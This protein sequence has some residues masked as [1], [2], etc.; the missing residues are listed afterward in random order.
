MQLT[1]PFSYIAKIFILSLMLSSNVLAFFSDKGPTYVDWKG[2]AIKG[3]DTVAYFTENKSVK[4]KKEFEYEW[5]HGKWLFTSQ[6]NL[7]TF[8]ANPKKYAPQY[9]GYC[10]YAAAAVNDLV[11]I[12]PKQFNIV[13]GKLY[14]NFNKKF[15][16]KWN[17][18]SDQYI[19]D[20]DKN[21]PELLAK[22]LKTVK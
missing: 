13:D 2:F 9:G 10:A 19:V 3:Y 7:D 22:A 20:G 18:N 16:D 5:N 6:Q 12:D 14:L 4:G 21:W 15:N 1:K 11:K 8:K 17:N